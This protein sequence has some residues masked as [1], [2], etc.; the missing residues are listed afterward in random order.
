VR[1]FSSAYTALK[2]DIRAGVHGRQSQQGI[3]TT[4][5]GIVGAETQL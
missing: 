4:I 2:E 1:D 3:A 5:L